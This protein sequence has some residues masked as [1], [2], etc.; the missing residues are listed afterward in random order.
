MYGMSNKVVHASA[1]DNTQLTQEMGNQDEVNIP[2]EYRSFMA[3]AV[4]K[5]EEEPIIRED[6]SE[7]RYLV[8]MPVYSNS[9]LDFLQYCTNLGFVTLD[10]FENSPKAYQSL[11][12]SIGKIG[13][14]EF[15]VTLTCAGEDSFE[16]TATDISKLNNISSISI[17]GIGLAPGCEEELNKFEVLRLSPQGKIIKDETGDLTADFYYNQGDIDFS[18]LTG[19]KRIE[20]HYDP[21]TLAIFFNSEEYNTL[22]ES[23]VK[24]G[25]KDEWVDEETGEYIHEASRSKYIKINKKLDKIVDELNINQDSTPQEKIDAVLLYVLEHSEYDDYI[26]E[27]TYGNDPDEWSS[28]VENA[29]SSFYNDGILYGFL[30][31]KTQ[32]CGNYAAGVES[33][34]DRVANPDLSA[35]ITSQSHAWNIIKIGDESY[36]L[37]ATWLDDHCCTIWEDS[38]EVE[39]TY[40]S[41][42]TLLGEG[43]TVIGREEYD[44]EKHIQEG[45]TDKLN[46]YHESISPE[47]MRR[48]EES[49]VDEKLSHDPNY[50]PSYMLSEEKTI[51]LTD[52]NVNVTINGVTIA[53]SSTA[54]VGALLGAGLA[55]AAG[56]KRKR[57][58]EAQYRRKQLD[59]MLYGDSYNY[60]SDSFGSG[61]YRRN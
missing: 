50:I 37:D 38:G 6:L 34:L 56:K 48:L 9:N 21:G 4:G 33:L 54:L 26:R 32:I 61:S 36:Y 31:K 7:L 49:D 25:F 22:V 55:I 42:G 15:S 39:K 11:S 59:S 44:A 57:N 1:N 14:K 58:R 18:K 5:S 30:Y 17:S 51:D 53:V 8:N 2:K 45:S 3:S 23:G 40:D 41:D 10:L 35:Y 47:N 16:L 46:W 13:N 20:F 52:K 60:S 24:V 19:L 29:M 28:E 27:N 43:H 12:K